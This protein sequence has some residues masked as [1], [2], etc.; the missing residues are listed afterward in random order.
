MGLNNHIATSKSTK[1]V[2]AMMITVLG[3]DSML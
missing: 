1:N 2:R 3:I